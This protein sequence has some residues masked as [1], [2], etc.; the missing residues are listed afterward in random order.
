MVLLKRRW[1]WWFPSF[2]HVDAS[3]GVVRVAVLTISD[4]TALGK[5][6]DRSGP[7][8]VEAV[9]SLGEELGGVVVVATAVVPDQIRD[10]RTTLRHWCDHGGVDFI[11]TSGGTGFT[12]RDVTPEAT[13]PLLERETPGL[14]A[15][16]LKESLKITPTAMLSR[17]LAGIRKK[18]LIINMPGN[19]K[20]VGECLQAIMPALP[21]ALRQIR[22]LASKPVLSSNIPGAAGQRKKSFPAVHSQIKH[23]CGC[24]H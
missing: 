15:A 7:A 5:G 17:Q 14:V 13:R 8:A 24:D 21:Q 3:A 12:P 16:M 1:R 10:I 2:S 9:K 18:T 11:I 19:P 4:T 23:G 22:G 6:P 20:A